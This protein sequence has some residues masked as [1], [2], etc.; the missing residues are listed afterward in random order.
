[1]GGGRRIDLCI[2]SDDPCKQVLGVEVKTVDTSATSGQL[3]AYE[4]GLARRYLGY[5]IGLVYLTPFNRKRAGD[6]ADRLRAV[7]EF[8]AF[9][10]NYPASVHVSWLDV[11]DIEWP[12]NDLWTQ[13][14]EYV[15]RHIADR[16]LLEKPE[17]N[18][19]F[20]HF[21]GR[22]P[23]ERFSG[24]L[25]RMGI[26]LEEEG[27][28]IELGEHPSSTPNFG[29]M[30]SNALKMLF[31]GERVSRRSQRSDRFGEELRARFLASDYKNIH[32][33]LFNLAKSYPFVWVKGERD[34]GIR[35][36]HKDHSGGVSLV[37]S[38]GEN[39]LSL[40]SLR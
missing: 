16:K 22:Q 18:R 13:H 29:T 11:A 21:F 9:S 8:D 36:A 1:M 32:V 19:A 30:L 38:H 33:A 39:Q 24:E 10:A 35:I 12:G 2:A 40:G 25:E 7:R 14:Q 4:E 20:A 31:E 3:K 6:S 26:R 28:R 27:A 34:Y 17:W 37:R 23:T 15:R 5:A